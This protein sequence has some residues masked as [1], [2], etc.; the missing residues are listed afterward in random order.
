MLYCF[1]HFEVSLRFEGTFCS[2]LINNI[3]N[4]QYEYY[5]IKRKE[6]TK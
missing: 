6:V 2:E 1:K 4:T 3:K 5:D